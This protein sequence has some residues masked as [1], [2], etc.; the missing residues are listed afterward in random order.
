VVGSKE[1]AHYWPLLPW[2]SLF[3]AGIFAG[4]IISL[5]NIKALLVLFILG[6]IIV[7]AAVGSNKFSPV[8]DVDHFWGAVVFKPSV[9]FVLG[10]IGCQFV[11]ISVLESFFTFRPD[12]LAVCN[13]VVVRAFSQGILW[14]Y[15]GTI[16]FGYHLTQLVKKYAAFDLKGSYAVFFILWA[17]GLLVGFTIGFNVCK[18]RNIQSINMKEL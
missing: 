16:I 18:K 10:T 7:S 14:I 9:F 13:H 15:M 1:G 2:Y 3:A 11:F 5:R 4:W 8:Y 12:C 6:I 17:I